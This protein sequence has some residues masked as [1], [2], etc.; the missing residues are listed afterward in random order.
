M[1][2]LVSRRRRPIPKPNLLISFVILGSSAGLSFTYRLRLWLPNLPII[3]LVM[4]SVRKLKSF[5]PATR[6]KI[7][8]NSSKVV[9]IDNFPTTTKCNCKLIELLTPANT[10]FWIQST[11]CGSFQKIIFA[12][13]VDCNKAAPQID[14]NLRSIPRNN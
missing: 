4:S 2:T 10:K 8:V 12:A 11:V 3:M 6:K 13:L 5:S 1:I 7:L 9:E 14:L